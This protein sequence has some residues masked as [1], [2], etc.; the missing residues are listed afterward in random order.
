M[1][2]RKKWYRLWWV[3]ILVV[4][5]VAGLGVGGYLL[6]RKPAQVLQVG[7][8]SS[9]CQSG[10]SFTTPNGHTYCFLI[11]TAITSYDKAATACGEYGGLASL[12]D[13]ETEQ[14]VLQLITQF[15][16][17]RTQILTSMESVSC[18][19]GH[20]RCGPYLADSC[21]ALLERYPNNNATLYYGTE[22]HPGYI[23]CSSPRMALN[24][25]QEAG[26]GKINDTADPGGLGAVCELAGV[27]SPS[28][29][30]SV[31]PSPSLSISPS[32]SPSVSP[33]PS[34]SISPSPSPSISVSP[35]PSPSPSPS[36]KTTEMYSP[37]PS[38]LPMAGVFE[39]TAGTLSVGIILLLLGGLGL[40]LL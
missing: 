6:G 17:E 2:I 1:E 16:T 31:S 29:S 39:V 36:T 14:D 25:L 19:L 18:P 8:G 9:T 34:L 40:L 26:A 35:S 7:V 13:G 21:T 15:S 11:D 20:D 24:L 28:P 30:P 5:L 12:L 38:E 23:N 37:A 22:E 4:L 10:G 32:P 33:S 3:W 27:P